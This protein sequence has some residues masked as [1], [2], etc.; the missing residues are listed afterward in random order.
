MLQTNPR[1]VSEWQ[2]AFPYGLSGVQ[3]CLADAF[4]GQAWMLSQKPVAI[5]D[6]LR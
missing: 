3:Q 1:G 4:C 6:S 2:L 5:R